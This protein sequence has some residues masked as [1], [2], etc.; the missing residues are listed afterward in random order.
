MALLWIDGFEGYGTGNL[1]SVSPS[2]CLARRYAYSN[3]ASSCQLV[4]G[5]TGGWGIQPTSGSWEIHTPALTTSNTL[6]AGIGFQPYTAPGPVIGFMDGSTLGVNLTYTPGST[7]LDVYLGSTHL[8]TTSGAQVRLGFWAYLELK[9]VCDAAAGSIV[10]RSSSQVVFSY[11]GNTKAGPDNYHN[12]VKL[13]IAFGYVPFFDDFY[14]CDGSGSANNDLL[15]NVK[16]LAIFPNATGDQSQW[17]PSGSGDHYTMVN[18][19][20]ANDDATYLESVTTGQEELWHY[21]SLPTVGAIVGVQINTDC[22]DTDLNAYNVK[23]QI[24]SGG[25]ESA[26]AAQAITLT[27]YV[28]TTRVSETDPNTSSAWTA[29]AINA[30]QFGVEVG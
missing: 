6:I 25:T 5:R 14:V 10:V 29:T 22:R 13:A 18:E 23:T 17:T 3:A 24:K 28:T 26:G 19:N 15:G 2:D 30:V 21:G 7:E 16:V 4:P 9:V 1:N 27:N 11:T 12:I 8:G 20:P